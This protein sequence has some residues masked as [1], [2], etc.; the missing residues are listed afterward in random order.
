MRV[1]PKCDITFPQYPELGHCIQC[2]S[3]LVEVKKVGDAQ[4]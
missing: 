2:G 1:C 3:K 4:K